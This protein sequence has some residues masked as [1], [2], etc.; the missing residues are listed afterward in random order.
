MFTHHPPS[1]PPAAALVG[2]GL[3]RSATVRDEHDREEERHHEADRRRRP[4]HRSDH[5]RG[6]APGRPRPLRHAAA[7]ATT[8]A[9]VSD[10]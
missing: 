5:E 7:A 3:E 1:A 8:T 6:A 9:T 10:W 2:P 4:N